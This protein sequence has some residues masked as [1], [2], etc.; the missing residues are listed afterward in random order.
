MKLENAYVHILILMWFQFSS[1]LVWISWNDFEHDNNSNYIKENRLNMVYTNLNFHDIPFWPNQYKST[2]S[3][4][5][6]VSWKELWKRQ[7]S[8]QNINVS[9]IIFF[10]RKKKVPILF[11]IIIDCELHIIHCGTIQQVAHVAVKNWINF[12]NLT[13]SKHLS[14]SWRIY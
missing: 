5:K 13:D 1:K 10:L 3:Y 8:I 14:E 2:K 11:V 9:T 4:L 12:L 7:M 6:I